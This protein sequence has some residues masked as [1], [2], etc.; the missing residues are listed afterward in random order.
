[1]AAGAAVGAVTHSG[2]GQGGA[3]LLATVAELQ[4]RGARTQQGGGF[5]WF[6]HEA[7]AQEL[8]SM[9][10][11]GDMTPELRGALATAAGCRAS[12]LEPPTPSEADVGF[13]TNSGTSFR[14]RLSRARSTSDI[15]TRVDW[16]RLVAVSSL[17]ALNS[18]ADDDVMQPGA[19]VTKKRVPKAVNLDVNTGG[20][21]FFGLLA[22][23]GNSGS[24]EAMV[25]KFCNSRPHL[26]SE[27][28][29]AELARHL[30]VEAP[31]SRILLKAHDNEEWQELRTFSEPLCKTLTKTLGKK[32]SMMLMR[33]VRGKNMQNEQAAWAPEL[34]SPSAHALGRLFVLDLLLGN[35]DRLPVKSVGWRGNP[36]N[37]L[38]SAADEDKGGGRCMPID[39]SIARRPPKF[40]IQEGDQN[41]NS[42]LELVLL[43]RACAQQILLESVSCNATASAAIEGDWAPT[44][45]AWLERR[46]KADE[47][48]T[49]HPPPQSTVKAFHEGVRMALELV[50]QLQGLLEMIADVVRSW[51]DAF[52]SDMADV[53][54]GNARDGLKPSKTLE[55]KE[56]DRRASKN[57][58]VRDRLLEWQDLLQSK[59]RALG[60]AAEDWSVRR[61]VKSAPSFYGFLGDKVLNP[62]VDAY[63]LLVRL[64]QLVSRAR[65][66]A[67]ASAVRRPSDL[68]PAPLLV[69]GATSCCYH[70]LRKLGVALIIN[71]TTDLP[72]PP[73]GV[74]C[75]ELRWTRLALEDVEDQDLTASLQEGLQAIDEANARGGR[76][77]VHCHEGRSR[78]VSLCLAYFLTRERRSLAEALTFVKARRPQS[79]PNAGFLRQLMTLELATLGSSSLTE[80]DLPRGKPVLSSGS[81]RSGPKSRSS[82]IMK[83][84]DSPTREPK[85]A[86]SEGVS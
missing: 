14:D 48:V 80:D 6:E 7:D 78:S 33:F 25:L 77:L 81:G 66:M 58:E 10:N 29:A 11:E 84:R 27:Q 74:L 44:E 54:S 9:L 13:P 70:L 26:Q 86:L 64:E 22:A 35:A 72:P 31:D 39:A 5:V 67:I 38:W 71:C 47:N 53:V 52:R 83:G 30:E 36:S 61:G 62:V 16:S 50:Q 79:R 85:E 17:E 51:L 69:G 2:V 45:P 65:V 18:C 49:Q 37:I 24:E 59:S 12:L 40:M 46:A 57:E 8:A 43:D 15:S 73:D 3:A 32:K 23:L 20:Q 82:A 76:I 41:V 55:L 34:L 68:S 60:L 63:E 4:R 75:S 21:V 19:E 56:I 28:L 1:V 42:I